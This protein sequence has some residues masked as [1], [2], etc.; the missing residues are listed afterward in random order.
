[1]YHAFQLVSKHTA[2]AAKSLLLSILLKSLLF[3]VILLFVFEYWDNDHNGN[4]HTFCKHKLCFLGNLLLG[5]C[6][7][8]AVTCSSI[9]QSYMLQFTS[10]NLKCLYYCDAGLQV[11]C[12]SRFLSIISQKIQQGRRQGQKQVEVL[13]QVCSGFKVQ[14][15]VSSSYE[16]LLQHATHSMYAVYCTCT[17]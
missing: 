1:M 15:Q 12:F 10:F 2:L 6:I 11:C 3:I 16:T 5:V 7:K 8:S 17:L 13:L 9:T 4:C 14:G